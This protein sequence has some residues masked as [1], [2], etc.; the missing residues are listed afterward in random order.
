MPPKRRAAQGLPS[1][2]VL[3]SKP[4]FRPQIPMEYGRA[5]RA[6]SITNVHKLRG[7]SLI[8]ILLCR[9]LGGWGGIRTHETH[10]RLP[11]FKTGAFDRSATHPSFA[12]RCRSR[13][14]N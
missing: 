1:S 13:K 9:E 14:G 10:S 8:F 6:N 3:P 4:R 5:A 7:I 2:T 11:V 12:N